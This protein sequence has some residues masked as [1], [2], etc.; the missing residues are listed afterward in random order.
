MVRVASNVRGLDDLIEGGFPMRTAISLIGPEGSG[1]S[2]L[3]QEIMWGFLERG[4]YAIYYAVDHSAI[5]V[6][7]KM[8]HYDGIWKSMRKIFEWRI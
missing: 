8:L 3:A 1:K 6:K 5:E 4:F 7:E 2:L